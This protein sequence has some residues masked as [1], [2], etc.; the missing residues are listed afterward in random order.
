MA[1]VAVG[2]ARDVGAGNARMESGG[3]LGE[4]A[5]EMARKGDTLIGRENRRK[6]Q[7]QYGRMRWVEV[8]TIMKKFFWYEHFKANWK[9]CW[10]VEVGEL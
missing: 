1:V 6:Q 10:E 5:R 7:Q 3:L 2:C 9:I 8:E 4:V